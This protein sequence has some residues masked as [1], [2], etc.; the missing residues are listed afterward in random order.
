MSPT[1]TSLHYDWLIQAKPRFARFYDGN[2]YPW[3]DK[4]DAINLTDALCP[5][6]IDYEDWSAATTVG[7]VKKPLR[8]CTFSR[9]FNFEASFAK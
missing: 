1:L 7:D 2:S 4:A 5:S 9:R 6:G 8:S 3:Y